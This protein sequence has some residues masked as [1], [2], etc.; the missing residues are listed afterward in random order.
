MISGINLFIDVNLG[1]SLLFLHQ[2]NLG[3]LLI[4]FLSFFLAAS[5]VTIVSVLRVIVILSAV[6]FTSVSSGA[7]LRSSFPI[8]PLPSPFLGDFPETFLD[9]TSLLVEIT[10]LDAVVA[11]AVGARFARA[12][13]ALVDCDGDRG[14]V[15]VRILAQLRVRDN[16]PHQVRVGDQ[17][18]TLSLHDELGCI[19]RRDQRTELLLDVLDIGVNSAASLEFAA[20][21]HVVGQEHDLLCDVRLY[22][23]PVAL[24]TVRRWVHREDVLQENVVVV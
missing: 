15:R 5:I 1:R 20:L 7:A 11:G 18:T 4:I 10:A 16:L 22:P 12:D 21:I 8:S 19:L 14:L 9:E 24:A 2:W 13:V 3:T 6:P 23:V 17:T